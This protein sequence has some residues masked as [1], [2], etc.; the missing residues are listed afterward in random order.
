ML[1]AWIAR[2]QGNP[3]YIWPGFLQSLERE[4]GF[5]RAPYCLGT[6]WLFPSPQNAA[7]ACSKSAAHAMSRACATGGRSLRGD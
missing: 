1:L 6:I 2:A 7:L 4:T 5:E 3:G